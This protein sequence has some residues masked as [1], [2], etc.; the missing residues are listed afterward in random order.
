MIKS[1]LFLYH[2]FGVA[3]KNDLVIYICT[4]ENPI[5]VNAS[6]SE[7][8]GLASLG[9]QGCQDFGSGALQGSFTRT[10]DLGIRRWG[11]SG[12]ES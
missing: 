5:L 1:L 9:I 12:S 6:G 3:A 11:P 4:D 10:L 7:S 2:I 8:F